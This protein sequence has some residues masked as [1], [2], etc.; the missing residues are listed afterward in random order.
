MVKTTIRFR[1][2]YAPLNPRD[3]G[4]QPQGGSPAVCTMPNQSVPNRFLLSSED[5]PTANFFPSFNNS[6]GGGVDMRQV[7][8]MGLEP[9]VDWKMPGP[10]NT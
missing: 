7:I 1:T 2:G 5:Y 6:G 3:E 8:L 9:W 10:M 4:V